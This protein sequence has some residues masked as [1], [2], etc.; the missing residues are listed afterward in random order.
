MAIIG[1]EPV[2]ENVL[3][4]LKKRGPN[5]TVRQIAELRLF[6]ILKPISVELEEKKFPN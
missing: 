4:E 6:D 1:S 3:L 2:D 5:L